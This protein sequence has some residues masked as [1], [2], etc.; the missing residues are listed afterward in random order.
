M[1]FAINFIDPALLASDVPVLAG[2][3]LDTDDQ[4][5]RQVA[6]DFESILMTKLVDAMSRTVPNSGLF[7]DGVTRQIK[8][9]FWSFLAQDVGQRG[10]MG[11]WQ[12]IYRQIRSSA[13][14]VDTHGATMEQLL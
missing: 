2:R 8:G 14:E 11:M 12:E 5:T 3:R 10:G 13:S 4:A 7:D 9:M 1:D 6:H